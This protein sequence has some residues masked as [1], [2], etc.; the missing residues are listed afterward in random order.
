ME[1]NYR[2]VETEEDRQIMIRN[3]KIG[4][5][6]TTAYLS[7][8]YGGALPYHIVMPLVAERVPKSDNT[9]MIPLPYPS[10]YVFYIVEN[11]PLYEITFVTQIMIS[12]LILSTNTGVYSLIASCVMHSCSLFDVVAYKM[13]CLKNEREDLVLMKL[14]RVIKL[15]IKAIE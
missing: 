11:S 6:F 14:K 7:L 8:S 4:R 1:D 5:F 2:D 12:T 10:D 13:E 3:A 15:H 9:T